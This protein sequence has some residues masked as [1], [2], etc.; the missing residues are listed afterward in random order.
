MASISP[1]RLPVLKTTQ[2]GLH[3]VLLSVL[4]GI[5]RKG[6]TFRTATAGGIVGFIFEE[7]TIKGR[8]GILRRDRTCLRTNPGI[9]SEREPLQLER[10]RQ[11]WRPLPHTDLLLISNHS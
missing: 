2:H 5:V 3:Y 7:H 10:G 4:A 1:A 6:Q 9:Y 11:P 8:A